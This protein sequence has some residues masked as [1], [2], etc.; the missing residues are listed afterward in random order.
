MTTVTGAQ[1]R[2]DD[3]L[4]IRSTTCCWRHLNQSV[5]EGLLSIDRLPTPRRFYLCMPPR[6]GPVPL[7]SSHKAS[8]IAQ[9]PHAE[10]RTE[11]APYGPSGVSVTPLV[12]LS[13][14]LGLAIVVMLGFELWM[15]ATR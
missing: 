5:L 10:L 3:E 7:A 2:C 1:G 13:C 9:G 12:G 15:L 4:N 14:K 11:N 6:R 8:A